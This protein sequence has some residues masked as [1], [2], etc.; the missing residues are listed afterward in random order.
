[1]DDRAAAVAAAVEAYRHRKHQEHQLALV[2]EED[3]IVSREHICSL[4]NVRRTAVASL[5]QII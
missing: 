1:M 3:A 2:Q 4:C 5:V